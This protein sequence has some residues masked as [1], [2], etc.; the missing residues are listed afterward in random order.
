ML[1]SALAATAA[2]FSLVACVKQDDSPSDIV[3]ALP[4]AEQMSIKLPDNAARTADANLL[5]QTATWYIATR[6]VTRT[7]NG[8]AAVVLTVLHRIVQ[9]PA[10]TI[11]G[12]VYTWGPS[13]EALSTTEYKLTVTAVG[14]GTYTYQLAG[15]LKNATSAP[16]EVV[17]DGTADPRAGDQRGSGHFLM[18][19]DAAR[20]VS[21]VDN[22]D[23]HGSIDVRYDLA[24]RHLDLTVTTTD[25]ADKPV[26]VD[27]AYNETAEGGG[28]MVFAISLNAGGTA[29]LESL[30]LRSRW[31]ATGAGR[32]DA[33]ASGGDLGDRQITS[34]E[35]WNT[36]FQRVY[37]TDPLGLAGAEGVESDCAFATADLPPAP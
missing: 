17:I 1:K 6:N 31:L 4:T 14:D 27:Y 8:G 23:S 29:Q 28:D 24:Q 16:F 13:S 33:R 26:A 30:T 32:A 5:G 9:F 2:V 12:N 35:C 20:R 37:Y 11:S 22:R 18:D 10:T 21:P 36:T 25:A 3:H 7:V 19:F 34:S 15:R